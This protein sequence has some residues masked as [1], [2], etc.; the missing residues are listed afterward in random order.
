MAGRIDPKTLLES[1]GRFAVANARPIIERAVASGAKSVAE[2]VRS[3]VDGAR[4]R[5]NN[6]IAGCESIAIGPLETDENQ[7]PPQEI[8]VELVS[9][10][11]NRPPKKHPKRRSRR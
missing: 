1:F 2:D 9:E 7:P 5:L 8:E 4:D 10:T 6:F 3:V 11:P